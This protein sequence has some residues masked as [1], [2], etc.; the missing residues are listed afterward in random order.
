MSHTLKIGIISCDSQVAQHAG[1]SGGVRLNEIGSTN[2][3]R[4]S[5]G[6]RTERPAISLA[7]AA[8]LVVVAGQPVLT[9]FRAVGPK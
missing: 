5:P 9:V 2:H 6:T 8:C 4:I 7:A 1:G 3:L